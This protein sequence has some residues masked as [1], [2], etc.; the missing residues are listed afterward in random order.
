MIIYFVFVFLIYLSGFFSGSETAF[1]SVRH[2]RVR[3]MVEKKEKNANIIQS[4]KDDS[5]NT[6]IALLI[7]NN[8]VNILA[9]SMA[10]IITMDFLSAYDIN[11]GYGIAIATG[12]MTFLILVFGEITPKTYAVDKAEKMMVK[13]AKFLY[14]LK[15]ILSPLVWLFEKISGLLLKIMG[16]EEKK[17]NYSESELKAIV[18]MSEEEGSIK[19]LEK[20]MIHNVLE[21]DDIIVQKIM[22]PLSNVTAL[23]VDLKINDLL[24]V[25]MDSNYSRILVYKGHITNIVGVV[26]I[27]DVLKYI[28]KGTFDV[29]LKKIMRKIVYVPTTKKVNTLFHYF[30]VKHEHIAVVVNEYGNTLG[31]VTLEDVL[32]EIVGDIMDETDVEENE[33]HN[34]QVIDKNTAIAKG[35]TDIDELNE[36]MDIHIPDSDAYE[37]IAGYLIYVVGRIPQKGFSTVIGHINITVVDA[38]SR[39]INSIKIEKIK[40]PKKYVKSKTPKKKKKVTKKKKKS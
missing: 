23:D 27:K 13:N 35:V 40:N 22:T 16:V 9:S 18:D 31:I 1:L 17:L 28:K 34:I 37:T 38:T 10:T 7:G 39:K 11:G 33:D 26:H 25:V 15:I 32:E 2:S 24:E 12:V 14:Y 3:E 36:V 20:E 8:I 5:Y 6:I 19:S 29:T 4:L 21:F 30:K